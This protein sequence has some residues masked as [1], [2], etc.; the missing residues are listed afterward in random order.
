MKKTI[1][2]LLILLCISLSIIFFQF[3]QVPKKLSW[4]EVEFTRLALDLENKPYTP[5]SRLATGHST[6][7]FY[8]ILSSIKIFGLTNFALRLPSA[9]FGVLNILIFYLITSLV[10]TKIKYFSNSFLNSSFIP[11]LLSVIL[12]SSRWYF[13]FARFSF[14][15]TFLLFLELCS[16]YFFIKFVQS[17]FWQA[18]NERVK[19]RSSEPRFRTSYNPE[20]GKSRDRNDVK[21][22]IISTVFSGLAFLSYYPGR[23]FFLLPLGFLVFYSPKRLLKRNLLIFTT[24]FILISSSLITYLATDKDL[25]IQEQLFIADKKLTIKEKVSYLGLNTIKLGYMFTHSGDLN[26]RHNYPGKALFNP[27]TGAF[28][29][30][31]FLV[32]LI[33]L[34]NYYNQ[35]FL[36]YFI[37]SLIPALFTYPA[38]NPN[39]LRTYTAII[40]SIYFLGNGLIYLFQSE[41]KSKTLLLHVILFLLVLFALSSLYDFRTYFLYQKVV[42]TKAFELN[43][44]IQRILNLKLWEKTGEI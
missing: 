21:N 40:P 4:D 11:F 10:F 32:A 39:S 27:V 1:I 2:E 38:E 25:R 41:Q 28:F 30:F 19:N 16:I 31:G 37:L 12:I 44:S 42:F 13:N 26:G 24:T 36:S 14:E 43:G 8:I 34:K 5:Y 15:A 35:F 29:L 6:L 9:L 3:N 20:R 22:L 23:I 33:H 17:S 7:Y 18:R